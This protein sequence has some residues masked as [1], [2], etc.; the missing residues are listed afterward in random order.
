MTGFDAIVVGSGATGAMAAQ[1]LVERGARVLTIDAGRQEDRYRVPDANFVELRRGDPEQFRYFLGDDLDAAHVRSVGAGAQLTPPRR[2]VVEGVEEF[3]PLRARN[4]AAVESLALGGLGSAWGLLSAVY[5]DAELTRASLPVASMRDAYQVVADRIG[6]SGADDDARPYT[7]AHL[8]RVSP[9]V[10]LDPTIETLAARYRKQRE[11]VRADGFSLGRGALALLTEDRPGRRATRLRDMDFYDDAE[12]A[13]WRPWM[14]IETLLPA[15]NFAYAPNV[16]VTRFEEGDDAVEVIGLDMRSRTE[17]RFSARRLILAAG[18]LGTAR[19][20]VRSSGATAATRLPLLSNAYTYLACAVPPRFGR[21][22]P[23]RNLGLAQLVI[24]HDPSGAHDDVA[25]GTVFS[26]RALLLFRLLRELPL[27]V[28]EARTLMQYVLSG[29]LIAGIDHPQSR[30]AGKTLWLEPSQASPTGD[31]LAIEYALTAAERVAFDARERKFA[32]LL[33]RLGAWPMRRVRP[34][35][36]SSIHYAGTLPFDDRD[37]PLHLDRSGRLNG[38]R[39]VFVADGSG[40]TYLP[41]KG[42]TL[43][44]MANAHL[45]A[46]RALAR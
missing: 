21:A 13:G 44:I 6:L 37:A 11:A 8:E 12:R 32:R 2:Y 24:A 14:T 5:S 26:Y 7:Y 20:V 41:A 42:L 15:P 39:R 10:P 29:F 3:A 1:T 25:I 27:G 40:F 9:S 17:T 22:M 36:G 4:F 35:L 46:G 34:P 18:V 45:V 28:R 43:S 19:V 33:R 16:F 30:T 38:T 23:E 31:A